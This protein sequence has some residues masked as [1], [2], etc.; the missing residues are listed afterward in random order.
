MEKKLGK[1]SLSDY[2]WFTRRPG[3]ATEADINGAA[4]SGLAALVMIKVRL[5]CYS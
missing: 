1:T 2:L 3:Q 4:H 5:V